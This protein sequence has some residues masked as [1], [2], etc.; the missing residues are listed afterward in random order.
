MAALVKHE[1]I[2][3]KEFGTCNQKQMLKMAWILYGQE[4]FFSQVLV[5]LVPILCGPDT[6]NNKN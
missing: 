3:G 1:V 6:I 5:L 2:L 4:L